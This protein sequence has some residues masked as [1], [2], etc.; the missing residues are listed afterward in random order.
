MTVEQK[1][2]D[3]ILVGGGVCGLIV[4]TILQKRGQKVL[5]LEREPQLGGKCSE[6]SW[7][8][9]KFDHFSKWETIYGS[10]DPRD[11]I[12]LKICQEAGLKLDW[13]EVHWQVGLIKEH[14]QKPELHS[15][16]DWSGG[17]AL[18]DF[19]AFMG[20]QINEDQ[21]KE[22]LSVLER[23]VSFTYEDLQ[24]MTSISLD[25]WINENI[26]DEL[27]RMFFSL[28]S[29]VTDTA[30]TE[31]SL[32]HNAWTMG[33]M[34]KGKSVYITFKGGSSMDVL[35]R[36]LE[37]LAKSHGAEIRVNN[38]VKEIVIENN[39]VQ[40]VWVSDN[41]TYLTK[42]VLA[43]NVIV[44]VPVYNAYPT[45]L[46][47]EMLSPGELAYVQRVIATYS[48]D[49]LCYYILEKG[50][51]KDLP[52]HFHGYD[53]TSGVPT[54]MGEIVQYKH[55]G[56]KVPKNVDFLMTYI[57]G[58]RSGL[59][60]LNYEGSPNEVSYELLDSVRCK[61]LKV[62]NDNMVPSF[63]SKIINSGV[64]WAPNYGRYSTMWFDSN[65]GVKSELVEGLYFASDS[66]DCS[67][68][69]TLG[70]EKVGAVATKCIEIVLQQRP[71]APVPPRG[72]LTPKRIRDR[73]ERLA[74]EAF[75]YINKVFNKDLAL[76][77]KEKVVLQY[78]VAGPR[79]GKWQLVVENGEYKISEGDAIQPVT[80]TMN[81]DS[82]ES[83][84][85][86]TTGEI[87]GLKAYTTGK[88]R[89]QGSRSVLQELNKI[90]PG[91][92]A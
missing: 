81:Y 1:K 2:Y 7:D 87:G 49:L 30:A 79:G 6:L 69:G 9:I 89:F 10:K 14:G 85:E 29:G 47:N 35:I 34:Y 17:K 21:K 42:K 4:A 53:L 37:K 80:V 46:K 39:K 73:R 44:N 16:N 13:Q 54:Y 38:T 82:V 26:K 12:F 24:K 66:V 90:I 78:N 51:T 48:K 68:V 25:R 91:G 67:C 83:F 41:L 77:L 15:I 32:P 45:L 65:L 52:G 74:N 59:G 86:V 88:L 62:I 43:K 33:N 71:A 19:A 70:L 36:P 40:G 76:K 28:G 3:T 18:L 20:V 63:E 22:L 56:A 55:F 58:G 50:T 64:I 27:V 72:A 57:P 84:V 23:W 11:G 31:Q 60:Y 5:V 61:L 8:G 92:K 75:D